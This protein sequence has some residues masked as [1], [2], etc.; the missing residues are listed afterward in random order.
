MFLTV[1]RVMPA[2]LAVDRLLSPFSMFLIVY[3][4]VLSIEPSSIL[5]SMRL[6]RYTLLSLVGFGVGTLG[7]LL[8]V[9]GPVLA[10]PLLVLLGVDMLKAVAAAQLQSVFVSGFATL[11]YASVG[12]VSLPLV[13]L[14]GVPELI[15]VFIGWC[16]AH[17]VDPHR[18][19]IVLGVVL[20]FIAPFLI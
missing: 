20:V 1:V 7:A 3:R 10:D 5:N 11:G 4:E 19:R 14:V 9:G 12:A 18:L 17:R 2:F 16:V 13:V 8:G 15:G 6:M